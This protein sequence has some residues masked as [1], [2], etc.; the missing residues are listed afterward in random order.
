MFYYLRWTTVLT[1]M[2]AFNHQTR[3]S[4]RP[5]RAI[6]YSRNPPNS[7]VRLPSLALCQCHHWRSI[8]SVGINFCDFS[9][10]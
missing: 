4:R 5:I 6:L 3:E 1:V 10:R 8:T 7:R 9:G 2:L